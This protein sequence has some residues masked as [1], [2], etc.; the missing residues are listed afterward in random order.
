MDAQRWQQVRA[1]FESACDMEST[2]RERVLSEACASDPD[3]R[4]EVESILA[5]DETAPPL[6]EA[7]AAQLFPDLLE[8]PQSASMVGE[9][10]GLY[11]LV[12]H[13]ASG[14]MGRVYQAVSGDRPNGAKVAIKLI[15]RWMVTERTRTH[16]RIEREALE[17][18][19]HPN[20]AKLLESGITGKGHPFLVM[21]YVEGQPISRYCDT[22]KLSTHRRLRLF[23]DVCDA[24]QYAH[25]NLIV[26]RD[27]KPN[28]ILVTA[29][30]VCKL[31]D[32]GIAKM[33]DPERTTTGR[34]QT[35]TAGRIMTPQY[36]S[37][38]Q[39]RGEPIA[40]TSDIYTLGVILYE[41]LTGH[42]P[43]RPH[44]RLP[45]EIERTICED[46]PQ[47]PS[48]AIQRVVETVTADGS[49]RITL[50][51]ELVSRARAEHPDKLRRKLA[52]DLDA[53]V[54]KALR[55]EP[56][57]RYASVEQFSEDIRRYLTAIPVMARR[58]T[59]RYRTAKL[60]RR[61]KT[62][63][64]TAAA[65]IALLVG[66]LVA[67][68]WQS[69]LLA[70]QR[71]KATVAQQR[72]EQEANRARKINA[73]LQDILKSADPQSAE[74]RD[75]TVRAVLDVAA[76][77]IAEGELEGQPDIEA[78]VRLTIGMTYLELGLIADAEPH[79]TAA[80]EIQSR[81]LG[82]AHPDVAECLN[83]MAMLTKAKGNYDA[84]EE[85]YREALGLQR[86][87]VGEES[88]AVA[89]TM[90]NLGVLLRKKGR[91]TQ[92]ETLHRQ[93]L[94]IRRKALGAHHQ[95]VATSMV[96]LAAVL[97]RRG[98][99][100]EAESLYHQALG[101]F[102]EVLGP[103]HYRVAV[104]M[105]NLALLLKDQGHFEQAEALFRQSLAIRRTVF[106]DSSPS[107][108]RGLH[109]LALILRSQGKYAEAE[110][111]YR[112][113]LALRRNLLGEDH[114]T[115]AYTLNNLAELL[116]TQ[117]KYDEAEP[118]CR[119]ALAIR[120]DKLP[121]DHP[122]LASSLMVMGSILLGQGDSAGAEPLL[123]RSV[124]ILEEKLPEGHKRITRARSELGRCLVALGQYKEAERLLLE[125]V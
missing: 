117:G 37:P 118:L 56:Q 15:K 90:N 83:G 35:I 78:A 109:N 53:I 38:E 20:I 33:L 122:T 62:A 3:L 97:K 52:G 101:I 40:T 66:G 95:D 96:N 85:L 86:A 76:A 75:T 11:E 50:T 81:V 48:T 30:G 13:I 26:H 67:M 100:A 8:E 106:G 24:V 55:K 124:A 23:R 2:E 41:L 115:V 98:E 103:Q 32:F 71:D 45:H 17:K 63:V 51:P 4:E 73:F 10:I 94:A 80:L 49:S 79:L 59:L 93:A 108:A 120:R 121:S 77:R 99:S 64:I 113:A 91:W 68:T 84:A 39:I 114:P 14:G 112:A 111:Q 47:K 22:Q 28:N 70:Q 107:V 44:R 87:A 72:A 69:R 43:Y 57:H 29:E 25:Q 119:Q 65:I 60:A 12:K 34:D 36:A 82:R 54:L 89:E 102:R 16:F 9:R 123:R 58:D 92:A 61:N 42:S 31:L 110:R 125:G 7:P 88:T 46:D 116:A 104:C 105:N 19:D 18:L 27:L 1:L 6:F 21:E 74:G 5:G